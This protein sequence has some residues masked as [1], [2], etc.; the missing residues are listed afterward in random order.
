MKNKN[1]VLIKTKKLYS[2]FNFKNYY[3]INKNLIYKETD[4]AKFI[5]KAKI[6]VLTYPETTLV[7][8]VLSKRPFIMIYS[9][10]FYERHFS[11]REILKKLTKNNIIFTDPKLASIHIN[12]YWKIQMIGSKNQFKKLYLCLKMFIFLRKN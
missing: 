8:A 12:R 11:T 3:K 7:E 5:S 9:K 2:G 10:K 1:K 4:T 6:L